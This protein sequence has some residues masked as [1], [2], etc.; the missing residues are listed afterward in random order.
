[1]VKKVYITTG[2]GHL[3][4]RHTHIFVDEDNVDDCGDGDGFDDDS[5]DDHDKP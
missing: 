3:I 2:K 4:L 5:V 1:M